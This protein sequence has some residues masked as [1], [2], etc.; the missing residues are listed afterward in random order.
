MAVEG[1]TDFNIRAFILQIIRTK[2]HYRNILEICKEPA[3][4]AIVFYSTRGISRNHLWVITR[5][6]VD[7]GLLQIWSDNPYYWKTTPR[8]LRLL[9]KKPAEGDISQ[10]VLKGDSK[11]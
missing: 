3:N 5:K 6:M 7:S 1:K 8:G 2:P 10:Y 11:W 9:E 4:M